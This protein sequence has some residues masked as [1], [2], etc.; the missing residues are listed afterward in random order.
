MSLVILFIHSFKWSRMYQLETIGM[1]VSLHAKQDT[2]IGTWTVFYLH[3][4]KLLRSTFT[5]DTPTFGKVGFVFMVGFW[6]LYHTL[7]DIQPI[8][9]RCVDIFASQPKPRR[10]LCQHWNRYIQ[11]DCNKYCKYRSK[12][13]T[14]IEFSRMRVLC[15]SRCTGLLLLVK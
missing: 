12:V 7:N 8:P 13:Q 3:F 6:C 14:V 5:K 9:Y 1:S 4:L 10:C 11:T 15:R 2:E